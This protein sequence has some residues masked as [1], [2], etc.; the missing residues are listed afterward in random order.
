ML[1]PV[2]DNLPRIKLIRGKLFPLKY[3][4]L[5]SVA[6]VV[7][8]R[9]G[10]LWV[11]SVGKRQIKLIR[12][13]LFPDR[14]LLMVSVAFVVL[15]CVGCLWVISVESVGTNMVC[16]GFNLFLT[17]KGKSKKYIVTFKFSLTQ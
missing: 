10:C 5:I 14:Y 4:P 8:C 13:K 15:C 9:V 3:L 6:F 16:R 11:T 2:G 17:E 7:L 12:G 1:L